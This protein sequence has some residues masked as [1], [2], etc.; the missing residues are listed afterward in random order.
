MEHLVPQLEVEVEVVVVVVV[1][2]VAGKVKE[3]PGLLRLQRSQAF[4]AGQ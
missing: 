3:G 4:A 1:V 2:V